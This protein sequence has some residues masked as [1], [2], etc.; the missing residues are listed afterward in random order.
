MMPK[1]RLTYLLRDKQET[2]NSRHVHV[3]RKTSFLCIVVC[4]YVKKRIK[5]G[6]EKLEKKCK[7]QDL[8]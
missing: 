6:M 2:K 5:Q 7:F 4:Y 8:L 1:T 3:L